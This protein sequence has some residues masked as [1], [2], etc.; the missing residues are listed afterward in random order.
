MSIA[1]SSYALIGVKI[2]ASKLRTTKRIR[3]CKHKIKDIEKKKFCDEC[4]A[5]TFK[6]KDTLIPQ[7]NDGEEDDLDCDKF[8]CNQSLC[9]YPIIHLGSDYGEMGGDAY[10]AALWI[11]DDDYNDPNKNLMKIPKNIDEIRTKMRD[12]LGPIGFWDE[13][14][15]G[16]W[17]VQTVS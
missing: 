17:A 10:V 16:L 11:C 6:E 1:Y 2:D 5:K 14:K 8:P 15:F 12:T 7:F 13:K 4:G 9:G 3:G